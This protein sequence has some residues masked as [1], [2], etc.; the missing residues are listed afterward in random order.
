[1]TV[2]KRLA[3][4]SGRFTFV[5]IKDGDEFRIAHGHF[6]NA[7]APKSPNGSGNFQFE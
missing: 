3:L 6:S 1:M 4:G 7:P 5:Y 2:E